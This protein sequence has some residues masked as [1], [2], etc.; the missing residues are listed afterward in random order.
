MSGEELVGAVDEQERT[1]TLLC[2]EALLSHIVPG[3]GF[4]KP[5]NPDVADSVPASAG[6]QHQH[7]VP[8]PSRCYFPS[9]P[10]E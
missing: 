3:H 10:A 6:H 7:D 4:V 2:A 5:E 8:S 9:I 1:F